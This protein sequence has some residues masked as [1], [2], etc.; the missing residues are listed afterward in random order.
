MNGTWTRHSD[1]AFTPEASIPPSHIVVPGNGTATF[2]TRQP[3]AWSEGPLARGYRLTVGT[4]FG[5]SDLHDTGEIHVTRRF[6]PAL[7]ID[8]PLFGRLQT[9][10]NG[11]WYTTDFRFTVGANTVSA[12]VQIDSALWATDFVRMMAPSD[13]Q[14]FGWTALA[15]Q[16]ASQ[17]QYDAFCTDYAATLL[18]VL[19]EMNMQTAARRL[20]LSFNASR[21]NAHT[22]VELLNLDTG[23]WILLDPT[24]SL[25]AKRSD[26]AWAS[27]EDVSQATLAF[28]WQA[29]S[30]VFL[31]VAGDA[32][33]RGYYMDY[34]LLYVNVYHQGQPFVVGRGPSPLPY[35]QVTPVPTSA[36]QDVYL[37]RCSGVA[38]T[39]VLI[40]GTP[41][42][43]VCD[44]VDVTSGSFYASSVAAPAGTQP[45]FQLYRLQRFVF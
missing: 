33:A 39:E 6:V 30:Y 45:S 17:A 12:A 10:I 13:N 32:Y 9:K 18:H 40:D 35:L 15:R 14:P 25:A 5:A 28:D 26:G 8:V 37:V 16:I 44:G 42:Q 36:S 23:G 43:V 24:F 20:D 3:F 7:P 2:D 22:L 27:A 4:A 19:G 31:G 34:P 41:R 11:Q 29:I 21:F 1:I 38:S